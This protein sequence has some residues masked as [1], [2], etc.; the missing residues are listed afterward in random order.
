MTACSGV[1]VKDIRVQIESS[2][3]D[4]KESLYAIEAPTA[5]ALPSSGTRE[6]KP[7]EAGEK[8][9]VITKEDIDAVTAEIPSPAPSEAEAGED[10]KNGEPAVVVPE[11]AVAAAELLKKEAPPEEDDR[12]I[13]QR[14]FSSQEEPCVM[15][16][17]P[18]KPEGAEETA[19]QTEE[20]PAGAEAA[21]EEKPAEETPAEPE[22]PE[23]EKP[24]ENQTEGS[25]KE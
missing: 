2:G 1:E 14:L 19:E 22:Q 4:A 11:A 12:P 25:E 20:K 7:K 16:M 23:E 15:P 9:P 6:E 24:A 10:E 5:R 21:A 18:E 8:A 3:P 13:H 17:P